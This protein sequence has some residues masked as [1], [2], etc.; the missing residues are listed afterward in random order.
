MLNRK[1]LSTFILVLLAVGSL[2]AQQASFKPISFVK[3]TLA[4]GLNVI[5]TI[6]KSAPVVATVVHY[7]IGSRYEK[8]GKTGY[9]HFFE[10]L[11]FE[12]TKAYKRA[13]IDK[14]V[15]EAGGSLNAHTS[16]DETVYHL[17]MPSN[18]LETALWIESS[19]LRGLA[20]DSVGVNTQ[21]GVVSEEL[22]TRTE[23]TA[24]GKMLEKMNKFLFKGTNYEWTV[25]GSLDDIKNATIDDFREFYDGFYYP[26]NVTLAIAGDFDLA[27][28]RSLVDKYFAKF[29]RKDM[30]AQ[31]PIVLQPIEKAEKEVVEDEK[32]QLP[33]VF[34]GYRGLSS[35][36]PD[37]YTLEMLNMI[38][39]AGESSRFYQRLVDKDKLSVGAS[40]FPF[41]LEKAGAMIVYSIAAPGKTVE[42]NIKVMDELVA[43]V[44]KNGVSDE[45]LTKAKNIMEASFVGDKKGVLE[46]AQSLARYNAYFGEPNLINTEITKY[47]SVTKEDIQ[48]VAKK[49]LD[50]DKRIVLI[51]NP[52]AKS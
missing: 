22:I 2:T 1:M 6:D 30:P 51:F 16:F 45:E 24:Y 17:K 10:H 26:N 5:Y 31:T 4:N 7:E 11:M 29:P 44:V 48:R 49:I 3:D 41:A 52:K 33:G 12:A 39:T 13:E 21:K 50:T 43:D 9:T 25:I 18:Y 37:I 40:A 36:D 35:L 32:A 20:V 38:L 14:F 19:R 47:L 34:I 27:E 8:P 28:A 42:D 15:E 46:K 23:N